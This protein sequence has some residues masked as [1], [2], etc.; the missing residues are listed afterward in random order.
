MTSSPG[1]QLMGV[2]ILSTLVS[3]FHSERLVRVFIPV[4]VTGLQRVDN[5]QDLSGVTASRS[6]VR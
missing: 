3:D 4:L 1:I 2:V 6:G 5:P